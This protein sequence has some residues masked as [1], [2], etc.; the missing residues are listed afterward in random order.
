[1]RHQLRSTAPA[2]RTA[3]LL[4]RKL[5]I[6]RVQATLAQC[7]RTAAR[8]LGYSDWP[9][10][11]A[12]VGRDLPS[13]DD[14]ECPADVVEKRR[15]QQ[16]TVLGE[17]FPSVA[18][19]AWMIVTHVGPTRAKCTSAHEVA[20]VLFFPLE[21]SYFA[22]AMVSYY[23][24]GMP[25]SWAVVSTQDGRIRSF[26]AAHRFRDPAALMAFIEANRT[27]CPSPTA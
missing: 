10:L 3:K 17:D 24:K 14:D 5:E 27:P 7:R 6:H 1:M 25:Q 18:K 4:K 20:D 21:G 16:M 22:G 26:T 19:Q 2:E 15:Q 13:P 9:D 23:Q 11:V 12:N 8:M